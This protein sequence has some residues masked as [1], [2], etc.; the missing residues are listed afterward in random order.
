MRKSAEMPGYSGLGKC[1]TRSA[2]LENLQ[3][4]SGV[5]AEKETDFQR[6]TPGVLS[7]SNK[8]KID[9]ELSIGIF[10]Y[11]NGLHVDG[12]LVNLFIERHIR[13]VFG[14]SHDRSR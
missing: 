1:D 2:W 6:Y 13:Q 11:T 7:G 14:R 12:V 10:A 4:S 5:A 8:L 9:K 3:P